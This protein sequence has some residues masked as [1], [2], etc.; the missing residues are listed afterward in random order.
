MKRE[1]PQVPGLKYGF[2]SAEAVISM[3]EFREAIC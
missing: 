1:N 2:L 3:E